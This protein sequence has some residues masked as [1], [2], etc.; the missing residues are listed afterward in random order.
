MTDTKYDPTQ[1][2]TRRQFFARLRKLGFKKSE[3]ELSRNSITYERKAGEATGDTPY[4]WK[5]TGKVEPGLPDD[6]VD[7]RVTLPKGHTQIVQIMGGLFSGWHIE[8]GGKHL[9]G[10]PIPEGWSL[11]STVLGLYNGGIS[12]RGGE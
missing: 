7:V 8:H 6:D 2:I 10:S 5:G 12:T 11:L 9:L 1:D 3:L 4:D